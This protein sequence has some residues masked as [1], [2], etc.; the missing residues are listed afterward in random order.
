MTLRSWTSRLAT[1][2]DARPEWL[3]RR[4]AGWRIVA[5]TKNAVA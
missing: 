2:P 5:E 3:R 1:P 4:G